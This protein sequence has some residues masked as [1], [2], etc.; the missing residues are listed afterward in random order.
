MKTFDF[1][2]FA[3][4]L[5]PGA[6]TLFGVSLICPNLNVALHSKEFTVGDLG[7]FVI[8]AYVAGHLTQAIGNIV[9]E[10]LW[11]KVRG[12][13]P[14]DWIRSGQG[15]LLPEIQVK[16]MEEQIPAKLGLSQPVQLERITDKEWFG[17]TRQ[18]YAAVAAQSRAGRVDIF[19]GNYGL[20]RGISAALL[21]LS[22]LVLVN[23]L[24]GWKVAFL[25][26]VGASIAV[27]RMDRF[28]K[29]YARELFVQFLQ[30]PNPK[31]EE[32]RK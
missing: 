27:Y 25:L 29:H 4:V 7:L 18:I 21:L 5:A 31:P 28:G 23:S 26:L 19:N 9:V 15:N 24:S 3:G 13:M 14:T 6:V 12:G 1:Y 16:A 17:V 10:Q 2:E 22:L 8:L 30:M 11:W 20:N 32:E